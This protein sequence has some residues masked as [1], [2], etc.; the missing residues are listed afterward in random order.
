MNLDKIVMLFAG[1]IVLISLALTYW[2]HPGWVWLTAFVGA[3]LIQASVTGFCPA[4]MIFRR[5]G[6]RKGAA[7]R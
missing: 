7:F 4:A 2:V 5:L 1:C 6:V 3:N